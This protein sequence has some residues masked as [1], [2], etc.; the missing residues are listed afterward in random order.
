MA[1][2]Q[3]AEY[4]MIDDKELAE[5]Y[6]RS[7]RYYSERSLLI[8][9]IFLRDMPGFLFGRFSDKYRIE[10]ASSPIAAA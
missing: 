5:K 7:F 3:F 1:A 8:S 6:R 9:T 10:L 4:R 2:K